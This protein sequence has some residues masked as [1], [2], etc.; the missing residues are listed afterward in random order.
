MILDD[1]GIYEDTDR[2]FLLEND[3]ISIE[4]EGFM[5]GYCG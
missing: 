1:D 5:M 3:E 2:A 4:E